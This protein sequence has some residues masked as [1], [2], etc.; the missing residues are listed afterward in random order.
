MMSK[1]GMDKPAVLRRKLQ[2]N[3]GRYTVEPVGIVYNTHR[4]RGLSDFQYSMSN[5]NFMNS[6]VGQV[7]PGSIPKIRQF[8][9]ESGT[10][11]GPNIDLIPPPFFAP[12]GM[13]N[14]YMY[15]QNPFVRGKDGTE[16]P[17]YDAPAAFVNPPSSSSGSDED[18][19]ASD[20]SAEFNKVVNTSMRGTAPGY[21]IRYND[22]PAPL[23]PRMPPDETDPHVRAVMGELKAAMDERPAWTRRSM[24]NRLSSAVSSLPKS[25]NIIKHCI[26]YAGFQ[27]RGG[28]W[29]DS[30]VKYGVD[31][32]LDAKYRV[33]QT[34]IFKLHKRQVGNVGGSWQSVRRKE[35][36]TLSGSFGRYW[37]GVDDGVDRS[38]GHKFDGT[39]FSTDGKVWQVCDISDP[40]LKRLFDEAVPLPECD[41]EKSGWYSPVLWC[42]A[43]AIMKRKMLAIRFKR[44]IPDS[45]YHEALDIVR[46]AAEGELEDI[47]NLTVPL[48]PLHLTPEERE[49]IRGRRVKTGRKGRERDK[50]KN[51]PLRI[52][53]MG[54]DKPRE[55]R[56]VHY[57]G[58][59]RRVEDMSYPA[60]VV[61]SARG[62]PVSKGDK[63]LETVD[64]AADEAETLGE[65]LESDDDD[66]QD[67]EDDDEEEED[68]DDD[69]EEVEPE[70]EEEDEDT[71]VLEA[72]EEF[73]ADYGEE[74]EEYD[75]EE[76]GDA[77]GDYGEGASTGAAGYR[78][79]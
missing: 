20:D 17:T 73:T 60:S 7:I 4:Y 76:D 15:S 24:F 61:D 16:V 14:V 43:K 39:S 77:G 35:V 70:E 1:S 71:E 38:D 18:S 41:F 47:D 9:I 55:V 69:E 62:T 46:R 34:L 66:D 8:S 53:H 19:D 68:D 30:L 21:F 75:E 42:V 27:F 5:S 31:P 2:D 50:N 13:P 49:Q 44:D 79:W 23:R 64:E 58:D 6:F 29:R 78:G 10:A 37:K 26:Q 63:G 22:F 3:I 74:G 52:R 67:D 32:R 72:V 28:P 25:G 56:I 59:D 12:H 57:P 54:S 48:P 65:L 11:Q 40:L 51:A 36:S 33:Y 45:A